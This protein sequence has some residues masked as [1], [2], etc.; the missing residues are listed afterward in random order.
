MKTGKHFEDTSLWKYFYEK[1]GDEQRALVRKELVKA[2]QRLMLVRDTFPTYTL[3]NELHALNVVEIMGELLGN[4][5]QE[6]HVL[7]AALLLMSAYYHDIGMV[8]TPEEKNGIQNE[9]EFAE[10]LEKHPKA[11][12]QLKEYQSLVES[13][14]HGVP[15]ELA[16]WYCRW[17]HPK[18]SKH[19][20]MGETDEIRWNVVPINDLVALLCESHGEDIEAVCMSTKMETE[21]LGHADL[22][23]CS[24]LLRIAD[25]LDFD[26]S[27][28]PDEVYKYLGLSYQRNRREEMSDVE[29]RKHLCSEGFVFKDKE[30]AER[31]SISFIAAPQEP[32]VEYDLRQFLNTIEHEL[33]KCSTALKYCS[34]RWQSFKLPH[35]INRNGIKSQGYTYGEY[36]FTLEQD[37]ILNLL[38]GENLYSDP[39][40]FIREL[41]QNAIDTTRHRVVSEQSKGNAAFV[42]K[43]IVFSTWVDSDGY[44][45]LRIDDYGMGMDEEILTNYFLK[46]GRS[47]YQSEQFKIDQ[48]NWM[49][50]SST[51][52]TPISRFGIGVLSCFIIGDQIEVSTRRFQEKNN[53]NALRISMQ[54]LNSFF[55]LKKEAEKHIGS[56][57]PNGIRV[58]ENYRAPIEYGT[59]IAVRFSPKR[60]RGDYDLSKI[61]NEYVICSPV[62]ILLNGERVGGEYEQ[63]VKNPWTKGLALEILPEHQEQIERASKFRFSQPLKIRIE[64]LDLTFHSPDKNLE[65]QGIVGFIEIPAA[66]KGAYFEPLGHIERTLKV[67]LEGNGKAVFKINYVDTLKYETLKRQN[68]DEDELRRWKQRLM[69]QIDELHQNGEAHYI[70][71][72]IAGFIEGVQRFDSASDSG[73]MDLLGWNKN[74]ILNIANRLRQF[75]SNNQSTDLDEIRFFCE[76][77][78]FITRS[79]LGREY[80]YSIQ[81]L[82]NQDPGESERRWENFKS[83][84]NHVKIHTGK[85]SKLRSF[86][87]E[88]IDYRRKADECEAA[89]CSMEVE[90]D[91][92]GS[93]IGLDVNKFENRWLSH[94]GIYVPLNGSQ[95]IKLEI[96]NP[97]RHGFIFY[98]LALKDQLRPDLSLSRDELRGVSW[99]IYS[100]INLAFSRALACIDVPDKNMD[101]FPRIHSS[102]SLNYGEIM[103][104][105]CMRE[106]NLW[107]SEK[108]IDTNHGKRSLAE[109]W[110]LLKAGGKITIPGKHMLGLHKTFNA[111][112]WEKASFLE[113]CMAALIQHGLNLTYHVHENAVVINAPAHPK[114]EEMDEYPPMFFI[115]YAGS[116][117]L[118]KGRLPVNINHPFTHWLLAN[119][120]TLKKM[121]PGMLDRIKRGLSRDLNWTS[122]PSS[123][124]EELN[125]ILERLRDLNF[126]NKPPL[127]MNLRAE[128]FQ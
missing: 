27:R 46:V 37:Q 120:E 63:L 72:R 83:H 50:R 33:E 124:V 106:D 4:R 45:W 80:Y 62:P 8:F 2:S 76:H 105:H 44:T 19:Y 65:G 59:S 39:Y 43:P 1:A 54:G 77:V 56:P 26:N 126:K 87:K 125:Q 127:E 88:A 108:V 60:D 64:P 107:A 101:I 57:M 35:T 30:R 10:F 48:L 79:S 112:H 99:Q 74:E 86:Y 117:I 14:R 78:D 67:E 92:F 15:E 104:D 119:T 58:T 114:R 7:E 102:G 22:R 94:N 118:R 116:G 73:D 85:A 82:L 97:V 110:G 9:A 29:W 38:M 47:Y 91:D 49:E 42:P 115:E 16:E 96:I 13:D 128:D 98:Y 20:L 109:I 68:Y 75:V 17:I 23:F 81:A 51:D 40:V 89:K 11:H 100:V 93:L 52:F 66:D 123:I 34:T 21:A 6:L 71:H 121:Y 90:W 41:V 103:K 70:L 28:S 55:V 84:M 69:T 95:N 24:I 5:L 32:A 53:R 18:R 31:Y 25:I 122:K 113:Y 61:L 3:H 36:R 111:T 12:L